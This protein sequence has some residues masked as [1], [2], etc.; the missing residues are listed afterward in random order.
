MSGIRITVFMSLYVI[1]LSQF[2]STSSHCNDNRTDS[3]RTVSASAR[4]RV[5]AYG[6]TPFSVVSLT[7]H[8]AVTSLNVNEALGYAGHVE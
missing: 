3:V 4:C 2:S 5:R 1:I 7:S 8:V 6:N